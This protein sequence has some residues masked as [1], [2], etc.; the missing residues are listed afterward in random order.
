MAN[1]KQRISIREKCGFD[2]SLIEKEISVWLLLLV[3][4]NIAL[5]DTE[6]DQEE[7]QSQK[8]MTLQILKK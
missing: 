8:G 7:G 5:G 4:L 1:N 2:S 6:Q 3:I